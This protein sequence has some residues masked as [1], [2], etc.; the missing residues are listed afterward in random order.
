VNRIL[1]VV[2][3]VLCIGAVS[4]SAWGASAAKIAEP[5]V[6][7]IETRDEDGDPRITKIWIVS[8]G[9]T[10]YVRTTDSNWNANLERELTATLHSEGGVAGASVTSVLDAEVQASA[11]ALFAEKYGFLNTMRNCMVSF[12]TA[13]MWALTLSDE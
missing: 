10:I 7:E 2:A 3:V 6:V 1:E 11:N 12:G 5:G 4:S 9:D 13:N 8:D